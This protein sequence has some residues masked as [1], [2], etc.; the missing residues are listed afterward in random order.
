MHMEFRIIFWERTQYF[1]IVI[2]SSH[3]SD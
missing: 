3:Q 1:S 2:E